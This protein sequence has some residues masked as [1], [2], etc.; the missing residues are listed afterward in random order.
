VYV[1]IGTS[2]AGLTFLFLVHAAAAGGACV[3][4]AIL[5]FFVYFRSA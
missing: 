4:A 1:V 2:A 5:H 3:A